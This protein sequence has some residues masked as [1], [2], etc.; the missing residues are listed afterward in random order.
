M[1]TGK[2]LVRGILRSPGRWRL[3]WRMVSRRC[4]SEHDLS[5]FSRIEL[6]YVISPSAD[7]VDGFVERSRVESGQ[8]I[9]PRIFTVGDVIY[10]GLAPSLHQDIADSAEAHS[11]LV[12]IKAEGGR[13]STSYKNYNLPSRYEL[14]FCCHP[15]LLT[16]LLRP[17]S[18]SRQRLLLAARNMSMLCFPEGGMNYDWDLTYIVDGKMLRICLFITDID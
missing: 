6:I 14:C 10:G 12:R 1:L 15:R 5:L 2:G 13:A 4:T 9:G 17:S 3:F 7:N 18:A 16:C 8:Y 11:A